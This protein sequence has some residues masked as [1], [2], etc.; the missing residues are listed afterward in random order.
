MKIIACCGYHA[1]GS[2]V[3]DDLLREM[4]NV[5]E[6][7]AKKAESL[8]TESDFFVEKFSSKSGGSSISL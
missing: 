1:T 4:D 7:V 8:K 6:K 3:I 2:G 5:V